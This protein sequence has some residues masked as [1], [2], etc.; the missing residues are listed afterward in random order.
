MEL[1][2]KGLTQ[3]DAAEKAEKSGQWEKAATLWEKAALLTD[4]DT[5]RVYRKGRA[6][7]AKRKAP[8]RVYVS[9]YFASGEEGA[10]ALD[11][12]DEFGLAAWLAIMSGAID[13]SEGQTSEAPPW[14]TS[15]SIIHERR[16]AE[17]GDVLRVTANYRLGYVGIC[18]EMDSPE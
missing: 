8:R 4:S 1:I 15:D 18:L 14:G 17:S 13:Y 7:R 2:G 11:N 5:I 9:S 12:I 16:D 10:A 3:C 6:A